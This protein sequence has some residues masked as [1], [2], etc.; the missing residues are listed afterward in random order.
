MSLRPLLPLLLLNKSFSAPPCTPARRGFL[1]AFFCGSPRL[2]NT[3]KS[4]ILQTE[5]ALPGKT[6][7]LLAPLLI[8]QM[9]KRSSDRC[10]GKRWR[11][12]FL[13]VAVMVC[14]SL[15]EFPRDFKCHM[16]D[17][18]DERQKHQN[19]GDRHPTSLLPPEASGE[20]TSKSCPPDACF[21]L[22]RVCRT[23]EDTEP[24]YVLGQRPC[25]RSG[26]PII[27]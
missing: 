7:P 19:L 11:S 26:I 4:T 21:A 13:F 27:P 2:T 9:T 3:R 5:R 23:S 20:I 6:A 14:F 10:L 24:P 8:D 1:F 22:R 18:D 15:R 25:R 17:G 16:Y 12:L